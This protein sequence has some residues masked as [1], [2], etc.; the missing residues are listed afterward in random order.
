MGEECLGRQADLMIRLNLLVEGQTEEAFINRVL[1]EHLA[2]REVFVSARCFCTRRTSR[3]RYQGG[4]VSFHHVQ[5]DIES[6]MSED[7]N[8]DARFSTMID[9]YRLPKDFPGLGEARERRDPYE[10]V[11]VIERALSASIAEPRRFIPY[12]Q[13]HEFEALLFADIEKVG[14]FFI[15]QKNAIRALAGAVGSAREPGANKRKAGH[16]SL[17]ETHRCHSCL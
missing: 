4:V 8:D 14:T 6:W 16:G 12:I 1:R 13:L 3:I 2:L 17:Q 11:E 9:L 15:K 7:R 10:K 5:R